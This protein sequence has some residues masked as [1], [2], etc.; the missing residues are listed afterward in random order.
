[1][2]KMAKPSNK[3]RKNKLTVFLGAPRPDRFSCAACKPHTAV[4]KHLHPWVLVYVS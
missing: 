3:N 2:D 4:R 1:M